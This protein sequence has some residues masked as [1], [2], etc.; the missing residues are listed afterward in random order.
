MTK[1]WA[2]ED[3]ADVE[4]TVQV[5]GLQRLAWI[6]LSIITI[7]PLYLIATLQL[8]QLYVADTTSRPNGHLTH[9][10][11]FTPSWCKHQKYYLGYKHAPGDLQHKH[12]TTLRFVLHPRQHTHSRRQT[13]RMTGCCR[14]HIHS[15]K[16]ALVL[17]RTC[18]SRCR[19]STAKHVEA[20]TIGK[21]VILGGNI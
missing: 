7:N 2:T 11:E 17:R 5:L 21:I 4:C 12:L 18:R 15:C 3:N 14:P 6:Q 1:T 8:Q 13:L 19:T 16:L 10:L 9:L 20:E